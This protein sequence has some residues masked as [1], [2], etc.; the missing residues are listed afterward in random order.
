MNREAPETFG[1]LLR[2]YRLHAGLTQEALAEKAGLSPNAISALERGVRRRPYPDTVHALAR[3]LDL[4]AAQLQH[5]LRLRQPEPP[6]GSR[7]PASA[8]PAPGALPRFPTPL[9]GREAEV[10]HVVASLAGPLCRL[11]TVAG[12]GGAGKT[13]LAAQVAAA[14]APRYRHGVV[15][16]P[17]APVSRAGQV[18]Y[19][20]V[21]ALDLPLRGDEPVRDQLLQA[22]H[23][24]ELLLV[25]DNMEHVTAALDL[26]EAIL[27]TAAGVACLVTSREPLASPY[28]WIL[29]LQ[30][31][32]VHPDPAAPPDQASPAVRLFELHARR[33]AHDFALD[34]ANQ[35][36]VTRIC[37]LV[38]GLPLALELAAAWVRTLSPAEIAAEIA[39]SLDLL[40]ARER[41]GPARHSSLQA[42]FAHS[43]R[44][45]TAEER[46]VLARLAVFRGGCDRAAAAAVAG[47]TLPLLAALVDKSLLRRT[48]PAP[49][50]TRFELPELLRHY[51]L[52]QLQADADKAHSARQRHCAHYAAQ[53][54]LRGERFLRG[55]HQVIWSEVVVDLDNVRAAWDWAVQQRDLQA[56]A[57]M[58]PALYLLTEFKGF[59][60]EGLIWFREAA[61]ALRAPPAEVR[62]NP[63]LAWTLGQML[64]LYGKAAAQGGR[65]PQARDLLGQGYELLRERGDV[66]VAT[67][68]LV[69]LGYT[70]FVLGRYAE[71]RA[72][73]SESIGLARARG[74]PYVLALSESMLALV[75]LA[76]GAADA[77]PLAQAALADW[78]APGNAQ[79]FTTGLWALS[80][81]LAEQ[82]S[83]LEARQAAQELL[84]LGDAFQSPWTRGAAALQ[85]GLIALAQGD[86]GAARDYAQQSEALFAGLGEPWSLTRARI[87]RGWVAHAQGER[88]EAR[89]CFEQALARARAL[90]LAPLVCAAQF[91]LATLI[92]D[93]APAAALAFLDQVVDNPA[94]AHPI[95]T[96]ARALRHALLPP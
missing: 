24:R 60:E 32:P 7:Q 20:L 77:L 62:H 5:L 44:L 3:A 90:Q 50:A 56:L 52:D 6:A 23:D 46:A 69:G 73:F 26:V 75:A 4:D 76:E 11:L 54:A 21:D 55:E 12:P 2:R 71:A 72:W 27:E 19:A 85:L 39:G 91:A 68:T 35:A 80:W 16:V 94:A 64:S 34:A 22:L 15:W 66:V 49:A 59:V 33:V 17:L 14:L 70:A 13:H 30:G 93:E 87:A 96:R 82:G 88:D 28:E 78:P 83:L 79:P 63:E 61:E 25:L 67:G 89:R 65:Y 48:A 51:A 92:Q 45:L 38:E 18:P 9:I 1:A 57:S 36:A 84:R 95:R 10:E 42:V 29:D 53:L 8:A 58:G 43:W 41:T 31:L 74:A 37:Q 40:A 47:A 81:V 86:A